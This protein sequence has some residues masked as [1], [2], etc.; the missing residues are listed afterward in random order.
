M[1]IYFIRLSSIFMYLEMTG[2]LKMILPWTT[3][4]KESSKAS[5]LS[6]LLSDFGKVRASL[7]AQLVKNLPVIQETVVLFLQKG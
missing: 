1:I 4:P 5:S 7:I 3:I 6:W 2:E